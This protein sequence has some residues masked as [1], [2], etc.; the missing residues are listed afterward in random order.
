MTRWISVFLAFCFFAGA[1]YFLW[2]TYAA[3]AVAQIQADVPAGS[4]GE[5]PEAGDDNFDVLIA[6]TN[7]GF[8]PSTVTI[9]K[10]QTVRWVNTSDEDVW[11]ASAVHPTHSLYP[12]KSPTDC[13]GSD[14]D[15]CRGLKPGESWEFTFDHVGE[16]RYHDHIHAYRTGSVVVTE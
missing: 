12:Q 9:R 15:A 2:Q 16:W 8:E 6:F 13:L 14:F 11:P 4:G 1:G 10:G 5:V 3:D 7:K